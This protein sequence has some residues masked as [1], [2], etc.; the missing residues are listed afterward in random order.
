MTRQPSSSLEGREEISS[1]PRRALTYRPRLG[2]AGGIGHTSPHGS[3]SSLADRGA[4]SGSSDQRG[5]RYSYSRPSS[6]FEED[7]PLLFAMSDFGAIQQ[8]RRSFEEARGG[9][10]SAASSKVGSK[11]GARSDGA[12]RGW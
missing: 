6:T 8:S 5:G 11:R 3:S 9:T 12:G 2:Q 10:D 4:R 1:I 7:E